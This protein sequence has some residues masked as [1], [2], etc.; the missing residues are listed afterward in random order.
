MSQPDVVQA[1]KHSARHHDEI[2]SSVVCGCFHCL[3]LFSPN[4]IEEW[5]AGGTCA[6]CPE[7]GVDSVIG[8]ASG[9]SI[10]NRAFMEKMQK[11]WFGPAAP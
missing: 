5:I 7:C 10:T 11:R 4:E 9:V 2:E 1:H 6:L 3:A 8:D